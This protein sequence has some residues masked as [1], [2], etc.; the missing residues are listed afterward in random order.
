MKN[1]HLTFTLAGCIFL[2]SLIVGCGTSPNFSEESTITSKKLLTETVKY[3][4]NKI[5]LNSICEPG[6]FYADV[7]FADVGDTI[8]IKDGKFV[9]TKGE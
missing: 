7:D 3:T 8:I 1:Y 9:I 5:S 6:I 4:L 2:G